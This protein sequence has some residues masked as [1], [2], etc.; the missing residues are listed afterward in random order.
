MTTISISRLVT[1]SG[2]FRLE[3]QLTENQKVE[4]NQIDMMGTDGWFSLDLNN[5]Q[6]QSVVKDITPAILTWA[7]PSS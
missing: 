6:V 2:T 1:P 3:G 4:L 5:L 7:A